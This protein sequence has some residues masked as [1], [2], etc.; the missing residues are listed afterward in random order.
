MT[1]NILQRKTEIKH[2]ELYAEISTLTISV[3]QIEFV[4]FS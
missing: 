1:K 3:E 2:N 4:V